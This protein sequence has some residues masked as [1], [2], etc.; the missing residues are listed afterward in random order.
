MI[1]YEDIFDNNLIF[2]FMMGSFVAIGLMHLNSLYNINKK[3]DSSKC[4]FTNPNKLLNYT[5]VSTK[6]KFNSSDSEKDRGYLSNDHFDINNSEGIEKFKSFMCDP[7][8]TLLLFEGNRIGLFL[9]K[10]ELEV[11][12]ALYDALEYNK[13]FGHCAD[14]IKSKDNASIL[15]MKYVNSTKAWMLLTIPALLSIPIDNDEDNS[16]YPE[17]MVKDAKSHWVQHILDI[18]DLPYVNDD[19]SDNDENENDD[20]DDDDEPLQKDESKNKEKDDETSQQ[21]ESENEEKKDEN[22]SDKLI[23]AGPQ[24]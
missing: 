7:H 4:I 24:V 10:S 23:E 15:I 22:N 11:L 19:Y 3:K 12:P 2:Y 8:N 18:I 14:V 20:E 17:E 16:M 13:P 9:S 1:G 21:K 6:F 5:F